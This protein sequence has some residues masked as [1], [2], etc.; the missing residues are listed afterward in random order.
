MPHIRRADTSDAPQISSL[1]NDAYAGY[2]SRI[3]KPPAPMLEDYAEAITHK[4]VWVLEEPSQEIVGVVVLVRFP[5]YLL[6]ENIAVKPTHQGKGYGG[7]LM[8]FSESE[9]SR[10]G[11]KTMRLYTN[12]KMVENVSLYEHLGW[13]KK[14]QQSEGGYDRIYMEKQLP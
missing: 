5:D 11:Y 6:L 13:V 1:V 14:A 8:G 4:N 10:M 2:I 7:R 3:G 12:V 9:A